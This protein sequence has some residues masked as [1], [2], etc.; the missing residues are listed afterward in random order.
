MTDWL[1]LC[2][3]TKKAIRVDIPG[4]EKAPDRVAREEK[5]AGDQ[6]GGQKQ[7]AWFCCQNGPKGLGKLIVPSGRGLPSFVL[8]RQHHAERSAHT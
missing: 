2:V 3:V 4:V 7:K 1:L 6:V 5:V 8:R